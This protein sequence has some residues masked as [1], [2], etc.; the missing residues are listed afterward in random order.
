LREVF[1]LKT[2][3]YEL[4][5]PARIALV[6]DTHDAQCA[7]IIRSLEKE[8]PDI[9]CIPGDISCGVPS[10]NSEGLLSRHPRSAEL[11]RA[12]ASVAPTFLSLGNHERYISPDDIEE[13]RNTGVTVLD[14]GWVRH[15]DMY[16][17]GLTSAGVTG[18][19]EFLASYS[20]SQRYPRI[21]ATYQRRPPSLPETSWLDSFEKQDGFRVLL[22]H[23]PEYWE[24][25]LRNRDIHLI[26]SGHAHG[27][28]IRLLGRG[29]YAPGQGLFPKYT[30]GVWGNMVISRG[31]TNTGGVIPRLFNPCEIVYIAPSEDSS[32]L[33]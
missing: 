4:D 15:G 14:N 26:L 25:F 31:L 24:P 1:I 19:L 23:H 6:A 11:L 28:Q 8:K 12:C 29:L 2:T 27:G 32:R 33:P 30:G 21:P 13:I 17:G 10:V 7:H 22:C 9:I 3:L 20:G 16:I 18:Y 5:V